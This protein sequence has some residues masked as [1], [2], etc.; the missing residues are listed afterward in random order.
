M[1][2]TGGWRMAGMEVP[3]LSTDSIEWVQVSIPSSSNL[4][5]T[6]S[7][8]PVAKDF[9]SCCP[10][11]DP[12]SYF[13]WK[14]SKS[15]SN[16][17]EL[18][19]LSNNS[20]IPRI[21]LRLIFPD[22]LFPFAFICKNEEKF[23]SGNLFLLYALT[24][25][26]VAFL[27]RLRNNFEYGT[28][29][30]V[31]T[32]EILEYNTQIQPYNGAIKAV[33]ATAGCLVIG[34]SDGSV[35]YFQLGT[36]D[37]S[38]PGFVSELRD[39]T[40]F[41]RLWGI[42]SRG[43]TLAGVQ[44]LVISEVHQRKLL[45]VLHSDGCFRVWDLST[46][47]KI[48][49][50]MMTDPTLPGALVRL[51]VGEADYNT[52]IIPLAILHNQHL[53]DGEKGDSTDSIFLHG[54]RCN[55]GDRLTL[56]LEPS[57]KQ[58]SLR[59]GEPIDICL[60]S[61]K[62][63]ILKEDGLVLHN[64]FCDDVNEGLSYYY[65]LQET[66][67][68]DLLFQSSEHSSADLFSLA[69]A[70][71]SSSKEEVVPIV[72]SVFLRGL[73][74]PGVH[75]NAVLKQTF[76]DHNKHFTDSEFGLFTTNG[77]KNEIL[78]LIEHQGGYESPVSTFHCWNRFCSRFVN[79]W[80]KN[81]A[82][83]GMFIDPVTGAIGLVRSRTISIFRGLVDAEHIIYGSFDGLK[84]FSYC[85]DEFD[86]EIQLDFLKCVHDVSQQLG[87][88]S[89]AIFYES[90]L[91]RPNISSEDVIPP[92]LKILETG[93][94]S[95]IAA[96]HISELG[97]DAV[98]EK[99][100]SNQRNLRKF[101]TEMF[102]S[103]HA[104]C[105]KA[106]SWD[107]ILDVAE[108]YLKFLV[109]QKMVLDVDFESVFSIN[110]SAT[111]QATSQIA[112]V[113]FESAFDVLM[114]LNYMISISGQINMSHSHVSRVKVE[115]VPMIQEIITEW[116]IIYFFGT[117]PS[118]SPSVEDF[119]SRLSSL[120]I[121]SNVDRRL[122]NGRLGKCE[123]SL[124]FIL[125]LS[126]QNFLGDLKHLYLTRLPNPCNLISLSLEFTSWMIWGRAGEESSVFFSNSIDLA[127][128]LLR[129]GQY[130]ATEY[131][132][133]LV[134]VYSRKEKIFES[135]QDIDR[136]MPTLLHLLGCCLVAQT[137]H[138]MHVPIKDRN[139]CEAVRCFFRAS[140][141][142]G[143]FAALRSL[144][145]EA[146]WLL[147]DFSSFTSAAAW[148]L[149]YYQW[150][151]QL[152]EQFNMND[153]ANQF[154]LAALELVDEALRPV[155]SSSQ[156]HSMESVST[157]KGRLWANVFKLTLDLNNYHDAYCAIISNPDEE[158]KSICLRRFIIVLHERGAV[159]MLCD[160]QFPLIG[161][162]EK[163]EQELARKA[164]RSDFSTKP[165]PFQLLYAFQMYRHNWRSA[166]SFIYMYSVRLRAEAATKDSQYRSL[167]LQE[168]LNALSAAVNALQLAHP[169]HAWIY[170]PIEETSHDKDNYPNK[171]ARLIVQ[172]PSPVDDSLP[173]KSQSYLDVEKLESEFVLT[174]AE[175]LLSLG[176]INWTSTGYE[177]PSSELI[178]LLVET[179]L[180]DMAFTVILKFWKG[181]A[182]KRELERVFMAMAFKCCPSKPVSLLLGQGQLIDNMSA[183]PSKDRRTHGLL[184]T[185]AHH[186]AV[187][188]SNGMFAPGQQSI[189]GGHWLTLELYLDKYMS[190]HPRLPLIVA[191]AL[192][193]AD[194]QIE[195]PL[196][197]V[198]LLKGVRTESSFG[199]TGRES[200]PASLFCLYV[201]YGR[202]VE[203]INL[204]I[205]YVEALAAVRPA[206][207]IHRKK[208]FAV[209]FPYTSIERLW[210][211]LEESVRLGHRIDQ[212]EKLKKLLHGVLLNHL[213]LL[214]VDSDDARSSII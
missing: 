195:L 205:E 43:P 88:A 146:G 54:L 182:L 138:E 50:N 49:S 1:E 64:L 84:H 26:G 140:S 112:K 124:A 59:E 7:Q 9:A 24:M 74:F 165:N 99:E 34:R 56:F 41:G 97:A 125:L 92:F 29:S 206:D 166:A 129:H 4:N 111:V 204:L 201:D 72:S 75:C 62:L 116:H 152:F 115:L 202:Y 36:V 91:C 22:T 123:F 25:S 96:L 176:N 39:D 157:V 16:I 187:Q 151:M 203:A 199:M 130:N 198:R 147:V 149:Q 189:S 48:F 145:H 42:L 160:G 168:R 40:G 167:A 51:W 67:I 137:Q 135:L 210:C 119:S 213:N 6:T 109:P 164:E 38:A 186:E 93:Y 208:P 60:T 181:S 76:A 70:A 87:K 98:S 139:A 11:G 17:L 102:M 200:S 27:I 143:A 170:S 159:K 128:I 30:L 73:F 105:Y 14:T 61:N 177:K 194:P 90:L 188:N 118:E 121:D 122:W 10:I 185:S 178:D 65:Q 19:E 106:N 21:G 18:M 155:D 33:A 193:S 214:K 32:D 180:Y 28:S 192:L 183:F 55:A 108:R 126:M 175:Y 131:L 85:G 53:V 113:M 196:W 133:S 52:G 179:N 114:L 80:Y 100:L 132:L 110:C 46:R 158:S 136:K 68:A 37:P 120:Q 169:A 134:D 83:C 107:K 45:F 94:S 207:V 79:N 86:L 89:S 141:V 163:V 104:L 35:G 184:S 209:W 63:W 142:K 58:I 171:K 81:N 12:P 127:L 154:A 197:L 69:C 95:S 13:I 212:C 82:A 191:G 66:F 101:S 144:P 190:F 57:L 174:S 23:T 117:T 5:P 211:L 78:S 71:F 148:K 150:V 153:A 162:V 31:P 77:L 103:F 15:H 20:E 172:E 2:N 3:L 173:Q 8:N 44:D 156:E 161:L 47:G